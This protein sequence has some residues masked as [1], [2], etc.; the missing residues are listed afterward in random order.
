[1]SRGK[2]LVVDVS[3]I[4]EAQFTGISNVVYE[5]TK[6]FLKE[7]RFERI[8]FT[9]FNYLVDDVHIRESIASKS[10]DGLRELFRDES[11]LKRAWDVGKVDNTVG[12]F[13]HVRPPERRYRKEAQLYFDFSFL[14]MPEAHHVDTVEYHSKDI[15]RQVAANDAIFVISKAGARDLDFYFSYPKNQTHVV[16][17]GFHCDSDSA[18]LT[19]LLIGQRGCEPYFI[20]LG[21]IEPRKNVRIILA[22]LSKNRDL[23]MRFRFVFVGRDAWGESFDELIKYYNLEDLCAGGRI[24]HYGYLNERQKTALIK[25]S[26]C[27]IYPSLFEG[28]G[29]P[30]LEAMA[31]EVPVVA[32]CSSSIPE[33]LGPEGNYFDPHDIDSF[34]RAMRRSFVEL[35]TVKAKEKLKRI[36]ARTEIFSYDLCYEQIINVLI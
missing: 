21:T 11:L 36:K 29:L 20:C 14:G 31:L 27:L 8:D 19:E 9:V 35:G 26:M 12:L 23:L 3:P 18:E 7:E 4:W 32:S 16:P 30:V 6:R 10:G 28:F 25:G 34:D 17:L 2:N 22:W 5:L 33:V 13:L 1:M 24:I 15:V